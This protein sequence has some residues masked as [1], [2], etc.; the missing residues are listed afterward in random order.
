M[1]VIQAY[2]LFNFTTTHTHL[3][4]NQSM[5]KEQANHSNIEISKTVKTAMDAKFETLFK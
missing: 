3:N 5:T 4:N 1:Y 2:A